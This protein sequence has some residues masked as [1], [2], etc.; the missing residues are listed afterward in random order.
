TQT[1]TIV[2]RQGG[3]S[4]QTLDTSF[5]LTTALANQLGDTYLAAHKASPFKGEVVVSAGGARRVIS[6]LPYHP[7]QLLLLTGQLARRGDLIDP[8]T[9]AVGRSITIDQVTYRDDQ[10]TATVALD[11]TRT[12]FDALLARLGLLVPS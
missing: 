4:T 6:G 9:G 2:D 10:Q 8:D 12:D 1:G 7:A 5:K 3:V 11:N